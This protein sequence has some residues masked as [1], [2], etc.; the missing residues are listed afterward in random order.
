MGIITNIVISAAIAITGF[1]GAYKYMPL[2]WL[3]A[4]LAPRYGSTITTIAGSDTLS[5]SRSVINT[6]FSNLNADKLQSGDSAGTLNITTLNVATLTSTSSTATSTFQFDVS[7][8][9]LGASLGFFGT[10]ATSTIQGGTSGTSTLQG[11]LNVLGANTSTSTFTGGVSANFFVTGSKGIQYSDG[12]VQ[13]SAGGVTTAGNNTWTGTNAFSASTT[14]SA[15][16]SIA[17]YSTTSAPLILNS[18]IMQF[19][20]PTANN[21]YASSTVWTNNGLGNVM[22]METPWTKLAETTLTGAVATSTTATFAGKRHLRIEIWITGVSAIASPSIQFNADT[23]TNYGWTSSEDAAV[24]VQAGSV[25]LIRLGSSAAR[26]AAGQDIYSIVDVTNIATNVKFSHFRSE[27]QP[28]S[29]AQSPSLAYGS[30]VWNNTS[31]QI[32]SV[33]VGL[34][35]ATMGAGTNITIYG[36]D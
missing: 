1:L 10:T 19:P 11:F 15:T 33:T 13:T 18:N 8:R 25:N 35:T 3:D 12:S 6:N 4:P 17:A 26:T 9:R 22:M 32:T 31:N 27:F 23:G 20:T 24:L 16:T 36:H 29:G 28:N 5:S 14:Q 34:G 7:M 21:L 30:G 2:S